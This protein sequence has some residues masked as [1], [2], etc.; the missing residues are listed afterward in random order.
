MK[1]RLIAILLC[2]VMAL[3]FGG[4]GTKKVKK[5]YKEEVPVYTTDKE[6]YLG[7]WIGVPT[8]INGTP[9]SDKKYDDN[10]R[11]IKEAGFNYIEG[12][13]GEISVK[14]NQR[15]L[16]AAEKY[17]LN[18]LVWDST[19]K[20]EL[21][22]AGKEDEDAIRQVKY[23]SE[24]R[25]DS[26]KSFA[27]LKIVDEPLYSQISGYSI[28]KR[29]FD[30]VYGEDTDKVFYMN[31][32]PV[33]AGMEAVTADYK[34]YIREYVRKINTD[35]VS[36][37]HYP[38]KADIRGNPILVTDFLYNMELVKTAAPDKKMYTFLQ[39][40]GYG[41]GSN[42]S[43][44]SV[45]DATFQTYSFL[46]FGGEGIQWFCYGS[47]PENDGATQF[48]EGC[49]DRNGNLTPTYDYVKQ[50]NLEIR[51]LEHIYNNFDWQGV[52]TTIG[53]QNKT[54]GENANFNY[55]YDS[56]I[57]SHDRISSIKA[58]QDT[59]TG[60]FKDAEGRDGFMVVNFTEPSLKLKNEVQISFKEASRAIV[61]KNGVEEVIDT[62]EN[63]VLKFTMNEGEGYFIIPLK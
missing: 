17:D 23:L 18:M 60:V 7:M 9:M 25:Y 58:T 2:G 62:D 61:V 1:K 47:P 24:Q 15:A 45:A 52:M 40:I 37:D 19:I 53:S 59:L 8:Q 20:A 36:Y 16:A 14:A 44:T 43:L 55:L 38:L 49:I 3:G 11:Y 13:Y 51:G 35:Y 39:S 26:Y 6:F 5:E 22:N 29:R 57:K 56:L 48:E 50:A 34:E 31:L 46:A 32:L 10:F 30:A 41:G 21:L 42:R 54:G 4:C 27:G 28:A 33:I 63:D 12:G